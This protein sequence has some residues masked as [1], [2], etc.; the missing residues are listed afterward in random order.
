MTICYDLSVTIIREF[1]MTIIFQPL[2]F[3]WW[4]CQFAINVIYLYIHQLGIVK[5]E[6]ATHFIPF[7]KQPLQSNGQDFA[8]FLLFHEKKSM[9]SRP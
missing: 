9:A 1:S 6:G 2:F 3:H 8:S 5:E 7:P 4:F